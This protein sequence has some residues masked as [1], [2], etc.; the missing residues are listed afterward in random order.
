MAN[1]DCQLDGWRGAQELRKPLGEAVWCF[2]GWL[3][4]EDWDLPNGL[5]H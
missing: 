4:H 3:D 2:Q 5:I 1:L